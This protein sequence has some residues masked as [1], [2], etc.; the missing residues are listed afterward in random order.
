MVS[1]NQKNY[2]DNIE[3][4]VINGLTVLIESIDET[5]DAV[6]DPLLSRA[7]IKKSKAIKI[8]DKEVDYHPNF[9]L[10]LQTK[11]ANPHYKPE[12]QAQTT[13]INF[14]V[15]RDG[16]EQQ[17]LAVVV[18]AERPDLEKLKSDLTTQ[19]NHFKIT[20]KQLEDDL[21]V[22]LASAGENVL[23][24]PALVL[25]LEKTKRTAAEIE[26]KVVESR[27]TAKE[28]D[29]ARENYR[30]VAERASILYFIL[31]DLHR[32]NPMYQFSLKAFIVVFKRAIVSTSQQKILQERVNSLIDSITYAVH[33]YTC[34]GLFEK[35][36]LTYKTQMVLQIL[37][38]SNEISP[39]ELDFLLRFPYIPTVQSPLDFLSNNLWGGIKALAALDAFQGIDKDLELTAK[40]WKFYIESES[41][42][43]EK[44]PGDW[45]NRNPLQR[46]CILRSLR[47]DRMTYAASC[48]VE[49]VMGRKYVQTR[50]ISFADSFKESTA[51][52]PIFFI[53]SPGVDP[54]VDVEKLG[55]YMGVCADNDNFHNVSLGQGQEMV[56]ESA[57][58]HGT[59]HGH[60]LVLQ[61][62]HLVAKWLPLLEKKIEETMDTS[63]KDFRLFI[64][65]EAAPSAEYHIIPQGILEASIKITNEPPTGMQANLHR[66]LDNF[67]QETMELCSKETEFKSILFSLCY[68]HA[69]VA[70]RRKFGSQGWNMVYP[71]NIGDLTISVYVLYN[72][73]EGNKGVPWDDLRYLFGE[74]MYG[75]HI[76]DEWDRRLC[77]TYLEELMQPQLVDGDLLLCPGF[78]APPNTDF[79]G[80]HQY[81]TD[82]LPSE[83]PHLYGMHPNA[84]IGFLTSQSENMF[85]V[86]LDLQPRDSGSISG[87]S[88]SREETV[89]I[90]IEEIGDKIPEYFHI[91]E[92]MSRI[93]E[94][95]PFVVVAFQECE[96]MNIL[97][98]EMRRSLKELMLGLKGEL[99]ITTE[100]EVLDE[101]LLYDRVPVGWTKLAYPSMLGL[102]SWFANLLNR[103]KELSSWTIDFNLPRTVWL[104]GFFNPQ[105]FLTAIMQITARKNE[106]P[107]DKMCLNVD[108]TGKQKEDFL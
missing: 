37:L 57:L 29:T 53:L 94:R 98:E 20:L 38:H 42:E 82:F 31:N 69:V 39:A 12:M 101:C 103:Y 33:L 73:L 30:A 91:A 49:E 40:R 59:L 48:F 107:L 80:Y 51:S 45:K 35:D 67:S 61:N 54:L 90:L 4:A 84:E 36:K 55:R 46:L 16:L 43:K 76:I 79:V 78:K 92:L 58:E 13:L 26:N 106:W 52:T 56:A 99:T 88:I 85:K 7:F 23:A 102:Q 100:M 47:P 22:R 28:I 6:L 24:D 108:I 19:Q 44:L 65:A 9:R 71:F 11:M 86:I 105:S 95:T 60:W 2:L 14:T 77:R 75:G 81:I 63:H 62:I 1:L 70:E 3:R 74:I 87:V 97:F 50:S 93:E 25:N 21:L 27:A 72:Y 18:K 68:F 89:K 83:S 17:L 64:S 15:T 96:R 32:I 5:V 66:A 10:I 8:G 41:P 34:R 104:S